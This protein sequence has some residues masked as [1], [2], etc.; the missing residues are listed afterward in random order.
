MSVTYST[1]VPPPPL[2]PFVECLWSHRADEV[3]SRRIL[4]DG[5][6]DLVWVR[7][8][9]V[10][11][12]GPQSGVTERPAQAEV[13]AYGARFH[14]GVAPSIF[15][16]AAREVRDQHVPLAAIDPMLARRLEGRLESEPDDRAAF[17]MLAAE[18]MGLV[19]GAS[20]PDPVLRHATRLLA[21]DNR[22]ADI[23]AELHLSERS[24]QRLFA[25][26]VGYGPKTLQRVLRFQ[27]A[28]AAVADGLGLAG[29]AALAGYADQ[30]HL[31]RDCRRLSGLTPGELARWLG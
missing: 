3:T 1:I 21:A 18:I 9:G 19:A 5:R 23:G 20:G 28:V 4:P 26:H 27:R 25:E 6:M 8:V 17:A 12:A 2:C 14:P 13:L 30:A 29:A 31:S 10:L 22:I 7:G 15:R 11:L 24:L 16:V